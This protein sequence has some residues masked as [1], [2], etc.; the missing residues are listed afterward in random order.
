MSCLLF[1]GS[2]QNVAVPFK[3]NVQI[4]DSLLLHNSDQRQRT[5]FIHHE[6]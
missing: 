3:G 6:V 1:T 2:F 4:L 5:E